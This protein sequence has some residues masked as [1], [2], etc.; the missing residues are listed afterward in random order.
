MDKIE[1]N[2]GEENFKCNKMIATVKSDNHANMLEQ[3]VAGSWTLGELITAKSN[4]EN[5]LDQQIYQSLTPE[6]QSLLDSIEEKE[7][8]MQKNLVE[9][10]TA[11]EKELYQQLNDLSFNRSSTNKK[12]KKANKSKKNDPS[13]NQG[14]KVVDLNEYRSSS[15]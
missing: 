7:Q 11:E 12:I 13:N 6:Q 2:L 15:N 3:L 8:K 9:N 10:L 1:I 14:D 4:F 5:I